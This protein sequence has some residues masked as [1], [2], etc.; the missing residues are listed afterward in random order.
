MYQSKICS[1]N[2]RNF[3]PEGHGCSRKEKSSIIKLLPHL[4]NMSSLFCD[5]V[6][7]LKYKTECEALST[8]G[9]GLNLY[10]SSINVNISKSKKGRAKFDA[11]SS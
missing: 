5:K 1:L 8:F 7:V 11:K 2:G 4:S 9:E 6:P 3:I 10:S